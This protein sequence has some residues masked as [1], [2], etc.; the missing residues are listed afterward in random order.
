MND[1]EKISKMLNEI[2]KDIKIEINKDDEINIL[3][4]T[5]KEKDKD[6]KNFFKDLLND[7]SL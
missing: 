1:N 2:S 3:E 7:K 4:E 5:I 6:I